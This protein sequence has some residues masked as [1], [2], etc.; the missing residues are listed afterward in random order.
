MEKLSGTQTENDL[1]EA[2]A[3]E[4]R[5]NR[6]YLAFAVKAEQEGHPG[7]ARLFRAVAE[8]E[9][10][11]A[12]A[13]L[14]ILGEVMSTAENLQDAI[15][16]ETHE[17][18]S[19]YPAMIEHAVKEGIEGARRTFTFAN[20]VEKVHAHLFQEALE[21]LQQGKE[22]AADYYVCKVCG[23]TREGEPEGACPTCKAPKT[24]FFRVG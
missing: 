3:G 1:K 14:R 16:G 10:I 22:L 2:F 20:A 19:M 7:I 15:S 9:T 24:A 13:H 23:H 8:A 6:R 4:S 11:H 17:F 18:T 21:Q 12:H 5:A